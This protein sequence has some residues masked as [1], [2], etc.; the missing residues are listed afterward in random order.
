MWNTLLNTV[1]NA[2]AVLAYGPTGIAGKG[3]TTLST[4]LIRNIRKDTR[5][6][7]DLNGICDRR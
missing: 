6:K 4:D 2:M 1:N 3:N 5:R 7:G